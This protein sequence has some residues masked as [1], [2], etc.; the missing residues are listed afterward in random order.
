[1]A[2]VSRVLNGYS[3]V[4]PETRQR[5]QEAIRKEG[6]V[7]DRAARSLVTGRSQVIGVI[8]ETGPG[9]P[10]LQHP[11]FQEVL[12]GLKRSL[13]AAAYDLLLLGG[14]GD[15]SVSG[16]YLRR[17]RHHRVEGAVL[18]GTDRHDPGVAEIIQAAVPCMAVDLDLDGGRTGYVMSN[19]VEGAALAVR[20]LHELGHERIALI[21]GSTNTKPGVD[22]LLG[23]RRE[24]ERLGLPHR[25]EY[26]R[27]GDYYPVSGEASMSTLLGLETPPT[28]VVAASDLMA[29]GALQAVADRDL[30]VPHDV[31]IVGFDDIQIAPLLRPALTSVRQDKQGLGAAAAETLVRLIQEPELEPPVITLPVELVIRESSGGPR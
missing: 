7:P 5:V 22:R 15:G 26:V 18:M 24:I 21:G 3:D 11:F 25:T 8:L 2:T 29:A 10:D 6:F 9:H 23:F 28:A 16:G 30:R 12:V 14:D 1:M 13:E 4:S 17:M 31:A 19:N 27:E 20:H